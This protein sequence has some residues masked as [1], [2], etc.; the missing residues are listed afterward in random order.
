VVSNF[1]DRADDQRTG[2]VVVLGVRNGTIGLPLE[3][4]A[5]ERT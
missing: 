2:D 3:R 4:A 1:D 5:I